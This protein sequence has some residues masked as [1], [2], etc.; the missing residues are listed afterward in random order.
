M[1][2]YISCAYHLVAIIY[3]DGATNILSF[4]TIHYNAV[5]FAHM[6]IRCVPVVSKDN[7]AHSPICSITDRSSE[8]GM[9][10]VCAR[11]KNVTLTNR[12]MCCRGLGV[13]GE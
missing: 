10:I 4:G 9:C 13:K 11:E 3:K 5:C 8:H 1:Y 6:L 7:Q 2:M 12:I